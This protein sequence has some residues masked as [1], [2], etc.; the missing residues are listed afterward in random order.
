[1]EQQLSFTVHSPVSRLNLQNFQAEK[2]CFIIICLE[3]DVNTITFK[4]CCDVT[5]LF[6]V[7]NQEFWDQL[8]KECISNEN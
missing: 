8:N 1:M 6:D 5:N 3:I 4:T 2:Y 7:S